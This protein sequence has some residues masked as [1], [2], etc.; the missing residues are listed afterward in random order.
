MTTD[1]LQVIQDV[2]DV[3]SVKPIDF[4]VLLI[5][6]DAVPSQRHP[7]ESIIRNKIRTGIFTDGVLGKIFAN[8]VDVCLCIAC[9]MLLIIY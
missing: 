1:H 9:F 8:H 5:L 7:I 2:Y 6:Y 3:A 4:L